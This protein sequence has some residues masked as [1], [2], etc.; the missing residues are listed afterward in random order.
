MATATKIN[1]PTNAGSASLDTLYRRLK[2]EN[3]DVLEKELRRIDALLSLHRVKG[4]V[5][6]NSITMSAIVEE[7]NDVR[8]GRYARKEGSL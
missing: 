1:A 7:V 5:A 2:K 8:A 3:S 6:E 4:T